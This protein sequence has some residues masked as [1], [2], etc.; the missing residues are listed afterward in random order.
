MAY[1]LHR[2]TGLLVSKSGK[3]KGHLEMRVHT[4]YIEIVYPGDISL[5]TGRPKRWRIFLHR[6]VTETY[7]GPSKLHVNHK[8]GNKFDN[9]LSN[10]EFVTR[11]K[12]AEHA[13]RTGLIKAKGSG[14]GRAKLTDAQA[15]RIRK[16][17]P[18]L[19]GGTG[20]QRQETARELA[21]KYGVSWGHVRNI[22]S[23]D[24]WAHL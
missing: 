15:R 4:G 2:S 19:K 7:F 9:R 8:N 11:N 1:Q 16:L 10:L 24:T 21:E 22:W 5:K 17:D 3:V 12:N 13:H 18:K 6:L 23:S 14:N 20:K